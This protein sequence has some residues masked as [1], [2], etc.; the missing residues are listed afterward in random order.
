MNLQSKSVPMLLVLLLSA[1]QLN[2]Y[3]EA[4]KPNIQIGDGLTPSINW[5]PQGAHVVRVYQAGN[6]RSEGLMWLI[7]AKQDNAIQAP[8]TYGLLPPQA[9][10]SRPAYPLQAGEK[11]TIIVQRKDAKAKDNPLDNTLNTYETRQTF[12]AQLPLPPPF[13][14]DAL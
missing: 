3:D 5:Q 10:S 4:Q 12:K 1:C 2:P 13:H 7:S 6:T 14:G 11:Y 8:I 9:Q